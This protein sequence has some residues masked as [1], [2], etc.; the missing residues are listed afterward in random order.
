MRLAVVTTPAAAPSGIGD[1]TARL[2]PELA[3]GAEVAVFVET[4]REGAPVAGLETRAVAS[5]APREFDQVLYQLGNESAHAF[6][7][8]VIRAVGG[9]VALHDWVLFDLAVAA[10]PEL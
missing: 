9:A 1:Y 7:L 4:G 8:P 3:R 5:L 6:M 10:A 2:L